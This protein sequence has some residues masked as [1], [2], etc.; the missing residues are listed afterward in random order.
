MDGSGGR[1]EGGF[2]EIGVRGGM[3]GTE[4]RGGVRSG[5]GDGSAK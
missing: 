3:N 2:G 5:G 4:E 1:R